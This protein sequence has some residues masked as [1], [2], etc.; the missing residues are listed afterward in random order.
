MKCLP[1]DQVSVET[2]QGQTDV[3]KISHLFFF[4]S[5]VSC[6]NFS[7]PSGLSWWFSKLPALLQHIVIILFQNSHIIK[8][9]SGCEIFI[10]IYIPVS[11]YTIPAILYLPNL[12]HVSF[13]SII[14]REM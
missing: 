12:C 8:Y 5:S 14:K 10:K 9:L 3:I 4:S 1:T 7:S 11:V 2:R 13:Y 6:E